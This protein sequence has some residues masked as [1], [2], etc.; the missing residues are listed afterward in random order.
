MPVLATCPVVRSNGSTTLLVAARLNGGIDLWRAAGDVMHRRVAAGNAS[1]TALD[2]AIAP[3]GS[4][5]I[6]WA[7]TRGGE[8]GLGGRTRVVARRLDV[9]GELGPRRALT[10]W[11]RAPRFGGPP[12]VVAGIAEDGTAT[13]GWSRP[14]RG[15]GRIP[16]LADLGVTRLNPDGSRSR[17]LIVRRNDFV[18]SLALAVAPDGQALLAHDAGDEVQ[19]FER[20]D[21][22]GGFVEAVARRRG[23]RQSNRPAI[24]L[25]PDGAAIVAW[26]DGSDED[27]AGVRMIQRRPAGEFSRP[28]TIRPTPRNRGSASSILSAFGSG[29]PF[30]PADQ[31]NTEL[32]AA[33]AADGRWLLT[34]GE[35]R[36]SVFYD[37]PVAPMAAVGRLRRFAGR[38][39]RLGCPC[40]G[41]NG[42]TPVVLE[43]GSLAVAFTENATV[44][45]GFGRFEHEHEDGRV[46]VADP[47][48][49]APRVPA[50][51]RL[52]VSARPQRVGY[53]DPVRIRAS[54]DR[55]CE[56]RAIVY[57]SRR[58]F[59]FFRGRG[60]RGLGV[61]SLTRAGSTTIE[62]Q[63]GLAERL[64]HK[65]G[66]RVF[67][68]VRAWSRGRLQAVDFAYAGPRLTPVAPRP[69][70]PPSDVLAIRRGRRVTVTWTTSRRV[71]DVDFYVSVL[72]TGQGYEEHLYKT[73]EGRG[74]RRFRATFHL[75]AGDKARRIRVMAQAQYSPF[76]SKQVTVPIESR[77]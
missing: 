58:P 25:R 31:A 15:G 7:Q 45:V 12:Y 75:K 40:R 44:P 29:G 30:A 50:A 37:A 11:V 24:A 2:A 3:N 69:F 27:D 38:P 59:P 20:A 23:L 1:P 6:A 54:C 60:L 61:A 13:I 47:A 4:A 9:A 72:P 49:T 52:R 39:R 68:P 10:A 74:R 57:G 36:T 76:R 73:V 48:L 41:I 14:R 35:R 16:D 77:G 21:A 22:D 65:S 71:R 19:V 62:V 26:R 46:V 34:W 56:L 53:G 67:I 64:A 42:V 18:R 70:P 33:L 63:P 17:Q 55:P 5:V 66:G 32:Q 8:L 51:P 28:R 43:A